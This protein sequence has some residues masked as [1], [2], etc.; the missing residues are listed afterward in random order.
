[1]FK[2]IYFEAKL[3]SILGNLLDEVGRIN[4][5]IKDYTKAIEMMIPYFTDEYYIRGNI[6]SNY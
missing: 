2:H 5:A 1:M 6:T 4:E 3:C